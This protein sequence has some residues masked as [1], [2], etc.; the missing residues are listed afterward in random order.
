M[1][2]NKKKNPH[3]PHIT[4]KRV[5][6]TWQCS[7]HGFRKGVIG[8]VLIRTIYAPTIGEALRKCL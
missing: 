4:L 7:T 2:L 6:N 3:T 5:N 1:Q 8:L